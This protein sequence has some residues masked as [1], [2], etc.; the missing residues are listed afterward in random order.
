MPGHA[1]NQRITCPCGATIDIDDVNVSEGVALCRRCGRLSRLADL[2]TSTGER[3][4]G[5]S[6][7]QAEARKAVA[8]AQGEPPRGCA[9]RDFGDR[10][11][12][13]ASARSLAGAAGLAFFA[14]FW[15]GIVSIFLVIMVASFLHHAGIT[16]PAW[17]PTPF[18]GGGGGGGSNQN[19]PLGMTIFM[20][21]FLTPF[22]LV[23][24]TMIGALLVTIIGRVEVRL[25]GPDGIVFTGVGPVGWKRRFEADTVEAV[26]LTDADIE[27]NGKKK[28]AIAI[29]TGK[30]TI[31][32]ASLL[33][34]QRRLW[35]GG[36]LKTMLVPLPRR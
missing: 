34:D 1:A 4:S 32:F 5:S 35:L 20:A 17:F 2:A 29:E 22:V 9:I 15:N 23:G 3:S 12:L 18:G 6:K 24:V 31:K 33:P 25:R 7:D 26:L 21:L 30:K 16:L 8:L 27:E 19:M 36:V 10:V 13:R 14:I 28:R 11:V